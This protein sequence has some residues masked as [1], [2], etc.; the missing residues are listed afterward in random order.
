MY[1][2]FWL[3]HFIQSVQ[4][5]QEPNSH[6][7]VKII[8]NLHFITHDYLFFLLL[9]N[10]GCWMSRYFTKW[11]PSTLF[12]LN[13]LDWFFI[14]WNISSH[15]NILYLSVIF[16]LLLRLLLWTLLRRV[17]WPPAWWM[18]ASTSWRSASVELYPALT[19]IAYVPWSITPTL[20]WSR[21]SG[22]NVVLPSQNVLFWVDASNAS[23]ASHASLSTLSLLHCQG[24]AV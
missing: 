15:L 13:T 5:I 20:C 22:T 19:S 1:H 4:Q 7:S 3:F 11:T 24:G 8:T 17:S 9:N 12:W 6:Q 23:H 16:F 14:K 18:I 2:C 10:N 21:T